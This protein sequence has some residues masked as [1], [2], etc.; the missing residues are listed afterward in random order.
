MTRRRP[1]AQLSRRAK[2]CALTVMALAFAGAVW[3]MRNPERVQFHESAGVVVSRQITPP[4]GKAM[5]P[6]TYDLTIREADGTFTMFSVSRE[7]FLTIHNGDHI[8]RDR[9][10]NVRVV[11]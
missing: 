10:G 2:A 6:M 4:Q 3:L 1:K 7:V 5:T 11:R 8:V 9:F